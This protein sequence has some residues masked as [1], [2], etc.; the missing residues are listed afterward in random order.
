MLSLGFGE[1]LKFTIQRE[2]SKRIFEDSRGILEN[3]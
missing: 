3:S 2:N 1:N